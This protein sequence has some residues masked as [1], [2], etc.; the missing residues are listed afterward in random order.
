MREWGRAVELERRERELRARGMT[1]T[2]PDHD[3]P[4]H[5]T[6]QEQPG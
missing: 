6:C 4:P 2:R 3:Q 5:L 1:A